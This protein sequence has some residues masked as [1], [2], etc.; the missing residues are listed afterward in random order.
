MLAH[1]SRPFF[2][3][4]RGNE[5]KIQLQCLNARKLHS[6][7]SKSHLICWLASLR[8]FKTSLPLSSS[9]LVKVLMFSFSVWISWSRSAMCFFLRLTSSCRSEMRL[10]SSHSCNTRERKVNRG[11]SGIYCD[12][13][14]ECCVL[15][16]SMGLCDVKAL[17]ETSEFR[18][19]EFP[20]ML[21]SHCTLRLCWEW[22]LILM[23]HPSGLSCLYTTS[24]N[25]WIV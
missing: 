11:Q 9:S 3:L 8:I 10:R 17:P 6:L 15:G 18:H 14:W 19:M 5:V 24:S 4:S 20:Q 21:F 25:I 16:K 13:T 2:F 1:F 7:Q 12:I 23:A 22:D